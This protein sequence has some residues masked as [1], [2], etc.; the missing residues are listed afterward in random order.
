MHEAEERGRREPGARA[1]RGK[2]AHQVLHLALSDACRDRDEEVRLAEVAFVLGHLVLE[3]QVAAPGLPG[4]LGEQAVILVA[5]LQAMAEDDIG[6]LRRLEVLEGLLR[7]A[8]MRREMA[9]GQPME[10]DFLPTGTP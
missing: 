1:L 6:P 10:H 9:V 7:L 8:E 2:V 5:V 4:E 3:D